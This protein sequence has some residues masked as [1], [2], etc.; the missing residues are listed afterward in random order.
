MTTICTFNLKDCASA[1]TITF[2]F[3][4]YRRLLAQNIIMVS[5]RF[6]QS[7]KLLGYVRS[8]SAHLSIG[9]LH[10]L[11][12]RM[13]CILLFFY[14]GKGILVDTTNSH[15]RFPIR[16]GFWRSNVEMIFL[17]E[18][19]LRA[20][21]KILQ[22]KYTRSFYCSHVAVHL[23]HIQRTRHFPRLQYSLILRARTHTH[24]YNTYDVDCTWVNKVILFAQSNTFQQ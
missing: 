2:H 14:W 17:V 1:R 23:R 21:G 4:F 16:F 7:L 22:K 24:T 9:M 8:S 10:L 15:S 19:E 11:L 13:H 12:C 5:L 20:R 6:K 18:W 3:N